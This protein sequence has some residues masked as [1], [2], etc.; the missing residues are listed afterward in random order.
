LFIISIVMEILP[1]LWI[2][3]SKL[4]YDKDFMIS[5]NIRYIIN[6]TY[7]V[8]NYFKNITYFN[9]PI[10][11][12]NFKDSELTMTTNQ[13]FE[14]IN[15]FIEKG[16]HHNI[17]IMIHDNNDASLASLFAAGFIISRLKISYKELV[18]YLKVQNNYNSKLNLDYLQNNEYLITYA[19]QFKSSAC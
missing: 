10:R 16:Y 2:G 3:N 19:K 12:T 11:D 14:V 13:L 6:L 7:D 9:I 8:P 4:S 15:K 17:G 5:N 18:D 1:K